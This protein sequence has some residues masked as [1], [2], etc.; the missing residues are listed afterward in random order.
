M[1]MKR[2]PGTEPDHKQEY[3]LLA[4]RYTQSVRSNVRY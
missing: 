3:G 4:D 2:V 1:L